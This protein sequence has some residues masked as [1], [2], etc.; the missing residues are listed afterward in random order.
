MFHTLPAG[1]AGGF[2][3]DFHFSIIR[4]PFLSTVI[5][6]HCE[7]VDTI[8]AVLQLLRVLDVPWFA[9]QR[10]QGRGQAVSSKTFLLKITHIFDQ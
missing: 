1:L 5:G 10:D 6:C 8:R 4:S 9:K 2:H 7:F 3:L